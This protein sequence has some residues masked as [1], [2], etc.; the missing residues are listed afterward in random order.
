[1][2]M[3]RDWLISLK[4]VWVA[5]FL[6]IPIGTA[7]AFDQGDLDELNLTNQCRECNLSDADLSGWALSKADLSDAQL[8]GANLAHTDLSGANLSR[9]DLSYAYPS[10]ADLSNANLSDANL[11]GAY[12][13]ETNLSGANLS[14]ANFS[15]AI[16]IDGRTICKEGSIGGCIK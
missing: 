3:S 12:L 9:A 4:A 7:Y 2:T 6:L 13:F 1:M 8:S 14:G 11:I 10:A 5:F 16:W 15:Y